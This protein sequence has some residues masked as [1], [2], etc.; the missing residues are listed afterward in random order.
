[1]NAGPKNLSRLLILNCQVS[2][3]NGK[4]NDVWEKLIPSLILIPPCLNKVIKQ[5]EIVLLNS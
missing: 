5:N 2:L 3:D 4:V 1:M